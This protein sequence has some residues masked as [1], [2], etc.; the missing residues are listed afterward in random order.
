MPDWHSF[1]NSGDGLTF[2]ITIKA[3]DEQY[4][5]QPVTVS[6]SSFVSTLWSI[7]SIIFRVRSASIHLQ[8]MCA[9][10]IS[11]DERDV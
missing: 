4:V 7:H 1:I 3:D 6:H 8:V 9:V 10:T 2:V 11:Y 5:E